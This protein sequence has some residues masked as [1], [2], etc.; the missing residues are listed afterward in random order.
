M[1]D[2]IAIVLSPSSP[3]TVVSVT[4]IVIRPSSSTVAASFEKP[5][6][7]VKVLVRAQPEGLVSNS[8]SKN[9]LVR[10]VP[11]LVLK[12]DGGTKVL[13]SIMKLADSHGSVS[14]TLTDSV[15]HVLEFAVRHDFILIM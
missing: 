3:L 1:H 8:C 12:L 9:R 10:A 2:V 11:I 15:L 4:E 13:L 5:A 7:V 6:V 14:L